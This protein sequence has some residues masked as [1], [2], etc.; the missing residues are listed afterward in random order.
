M[1]TQRSFPEAVWKWLGDVGFLLFITLAA[2]VTAVILVIHFETQ[3][4]NFEHDCQAAGNHI[5]KFNN[6]EV[7]LTSDNT[8]VSGH[9][10][11]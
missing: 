8:Y 3:Q 6:S 11:S 9:D 10:G 5:V 7:C 2:V 4:H 1:K